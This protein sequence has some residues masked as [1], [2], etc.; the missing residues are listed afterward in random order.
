MST[1]RLLVLGCVRERGHAN[2]Y[3][4]RADLEDW[5]ADLWGKIQRGSIYHALR[6]L[7]RDGYLEVVEHAQA[8]AGPAPTVL[9]C[10]TPSGAYEFFNL[11]RAS[12]ASS[13]SDL[14]LLT[15]AVGFITA[16]PRDE[17]IELLRTRSAAFQE[18]RNS[19]QCMLNRTDQDWHHHIE[20]LRLWLATAESGDAWTM[21]LIGR[22]EAGQYEM[23]KEFATN[24]SESDKV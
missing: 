4:V 7:H 6:Q 23:A 22:L 24:T 8:S 13:E 14:G 15:A 17:A 2:G 11:L 16:L 12:L 18:R 1:T 20:A 21:D 5:G 3:Q 19:I 9:Y 10:L